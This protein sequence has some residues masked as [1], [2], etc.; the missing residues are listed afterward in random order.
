MFSS[1]RKCAKNR[2]KYKDLIIGWHVKTS[3]EKG[4][5]YQGARK[6]SNTKLKA[7]LF[8]AQVGHVSS[9]RL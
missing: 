7:Y 9:I 2:H 6:N 1:I 3:N 4:K 5:K 8:Y